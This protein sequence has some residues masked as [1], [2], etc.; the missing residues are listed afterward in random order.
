M[1]ANEIPINEALSPTL[2]EH[3]L[4]PPGDGVYTVHTGRDKKNKLRQTLFAQTDDQKV[5]EGWKKQIQTF[6]QSKGAS[7]AQKNPIFV[8]GIPSDTGGGILRGANWGPLAIRD[9]WYEQLLGHSEYTNANLQL[10]NLFDLGDVRTIPHLLH[11]KYL[12]QTT[13]K[14]CQI[15]LYPHLPTQVK[16]TLPVSP[17]SIAEMALDIIYSHHPD[18][19]VLGFGGDHSVSYPL[20]KSFLKKENQRGYK[21]GILHFDAHTDLLDQ[22][23]GI[24]ICFGSWAYHANHWTNKPQSLVQVGI[25]SSGK[26]R[27]HWESSQNIKQFWSNEVFEL[28]VELIVE[29]IINHF[30]SQ[31][32]DRLYISFDIDA[33][34]SRYAS[35]TGTPEDSGL[36]PYQVGIII[37]SVAKHFTIAGADI[38]ELAPFTGN[39]DNHKKSLENTLQSTCHTANKLLLALLGSNPS[40][41]STN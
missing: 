10:K 34:D 26:D 24:D 39:A 41:A 32:I 13:I 21:T 20:V 5:L 4:C 36:Q 1:G 28:G 12:N 6:S 29:R 11:D 30:K 15:A 9:V 37:E 19:K 33:L 7:E 23:L 17:L 40:K 18:A 38:T 25:R 3:L 8:L 27:G 16:Q 35:A 31:G 22:R 2:L 14:N